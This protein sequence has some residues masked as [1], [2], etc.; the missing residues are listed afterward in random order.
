MLISPLSTILMLQPESPPMAL[1]QADPVA[2]WT[3]MQ[4]RISSQQRDVQRELASHSGPEGE[5]PEH[6]PEAIELVNKMIF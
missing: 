6:S 5:N 3:G 1:R 4:N 2:D